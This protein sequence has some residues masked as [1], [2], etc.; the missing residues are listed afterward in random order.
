MAVLQSSN[1][2]SRLSDITTSHANNSFTELPPST[3]LMGRSSGPIFSLRGL[4]FS[5]WQNEQKRS[6]TV[7]GRDLM[8]TPSVDEAP[9]TWPPLMPPPATATLKQRG[10]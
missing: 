5:D 7:T 1:H 4:I 10:K 9:M 6:G 3:I 2:F 8:S